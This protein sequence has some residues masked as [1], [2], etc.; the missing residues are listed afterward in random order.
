MNRL[1][2]ASAFFALLGMSTRSFTADE[3]HPTQKVDCSFAPSQSLVVNRISGAAAG[4][5][6]TAYALAQATGLTVVSHS[7]GAYILT[8]AG[9]YV[10]GTLGGAV[11][12]PAIVV[13]GL[14]VGGAAVTVELICAPKNHPAEV[15]KIRDASEEF[16]RRSRE[17]LNKAPAVL[18]D[19]RNS[20][21]S[22]SDKTTVKIKEVSGNA[23][24]YAYRASRD[25]SGRFGN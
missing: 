19:A 14:L 15:A 9:G 25:V 17:A 3:Q 18:A 23:Y 12:G 21:V 10:A 24:E 4:A 13:V 20:A 1:A 5:S 7:S 16:R 22:L 8:G 2:F 11:V 6:A